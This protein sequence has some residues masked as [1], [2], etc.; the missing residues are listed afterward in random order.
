MNKET[1]LREALKLAER[2][3]GACDSLRILAE[4]PA[5]PFPIPA[6]VSMSPD[7]YLSPPNPAR[8]EKWEGAMA[9]AFLGRMTRRSREPRTMWWDPDRAPS[10]VAAASKSTRKT[11]RHVPDRSFCTGKSP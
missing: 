6:G 9:Q 2:V 5:S 3:V 4:Y 11:T 7:W 8:L 10:N 1:E